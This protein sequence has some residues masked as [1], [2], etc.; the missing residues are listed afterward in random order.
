MQTRYL[1]KSGLEV[2]ALGLGCMGLS[3]GNGYASGR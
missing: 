1:G 3:F 2:S